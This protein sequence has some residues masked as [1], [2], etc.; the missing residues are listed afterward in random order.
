MAGETLEKRRQ[1]AGEFVTYVD[2]LNQYLA[3]AA[4]KASEIAAAGLT[5]VDTDFEGADAVGLHHLTAALLEDALEQLN[6][7]EPTS[8][9]FWMLDNGVDV[10]FAKVR[11]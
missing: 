5:F 1:E 3:L 7:Q 4:T 9:V 11:P 6:Y 2:Q 8:L 10:K